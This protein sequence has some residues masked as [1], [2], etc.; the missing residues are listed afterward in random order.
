MMSILMLGG[1]ADMGQVQKQRSTNN[2][3]YDIHNLKI[4]EEG[5]AIDFMPKAYELD[6]F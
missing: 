6:D 2:M 4:I 3:V 5:W 1:C